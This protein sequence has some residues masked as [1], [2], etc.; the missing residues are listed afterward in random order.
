MTEQQ[1]QIHRRQHGEM[2]IPKEGCYTLVLWLPSF[3]YESKWE[4]R[5]RKREEG[6]I[7]GAEQETSTQLGLLKK[8]GAAKEENEKGLSLQCSQ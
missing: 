5:T 8:A 6:M 4:I 3:N 2:M 1:S 7:A